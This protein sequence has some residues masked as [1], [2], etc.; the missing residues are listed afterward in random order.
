ML[1][2]L[3]PLVIFCIFLRISLS[4][5]MAQ[6]VV[7]N[8]ICTSPAP[9]IYGSTINANSLYNI[10][11]DEQPP[12][13]REWIELYNDHPCNSADISCY[14]LA[15]NMLQQTT[16]GTTP[17]WGAF[18]FPAGTVIPPLGFIIVGGNNSQVPLLDFN[19]NYYRQ[20][21][22]GVQYLDGDPTRWFLRDEYG[23]LALYAPD[24]SVIDAVYWDAY[25]NPSNINFQPEYQQNVVTQTSCSGTQ[26]LAAARNIPDIEF[27]GAC[28]SGTNVS[29]QRT[30]DGSDEWASGPQIPTPHVCNSNC[31]G[32]PILTFS[33]QNTGCQGN[34]GSITIY[35]QDGHT[36]PYTI[37]WLQPA[38]LHSP[39][40]EGLAPG[41]YIVQ[42]VDAYDCFIVYDTITVTG[43]SNPEVFIDSVLNEMCSYSNGAIY[44]HA[45]AGSP[46]YSYLWTPSNQNS[47]NLTGVH[48]GNYSVLVTDING[49][50]AT[51]QAEITNTPPPIVFFEYIYPDTCHKQ[52]GAASVVVLGGF[53]PYQYHWS[54]SDSI[55]GT[56]VSCLNEGNYS[57]TVTDSLCQVLVP[58]NIPLIPG[59][60]ADF[61]TYPPVTTIDNPSFR[62]EDWSFGVINDWH[63][64]FGD[65]TGS[66]GKDA[67]HTY[68]DT[69]KYK[70]VLQISNK[71]GCKDTISKM[72]I[73]LDK[74]TL[75]I[76]NSFTPNGDGINDYFFALGQNIMDYEFYLYNRWGEL[77][78]HSEDIYQQWDGKYK[79]KIVEESVYNWVVF[80]TEDRAGII[81]TPK[82]MKGS[83]TIIK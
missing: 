47:Q 64:N 52:T 12:Y 24:G 45:I 80:Y 31:T 56:A 2:K 13:N 66:D 51:A 21:S 55:Y 29:F 77:I 17:N 23:W 67:F 58:F 4:T 26:S 46:P 20:N 59:P 8:E 28:Q 43:T 39:T 60:E 14:T 48:A 15:G 18:T 49:C 62:F 63:W 35:I 5:V 11:V 1:K 22:F 36:G 32:P 53:P 41:T 6:F 3:F 9:G 68:A 7:I 79:G 82:A 50:T 10:M 81:R 73:V 37:N 70:V 42:V 33:V 54:V 38:G 61:K 72:I 76:P 34:D 27:L 44:I 78:F 40:I 19:L 65:G 71:E 30:Y 75:F 57:L 69:G 25:G 74:I 83:L 16:T